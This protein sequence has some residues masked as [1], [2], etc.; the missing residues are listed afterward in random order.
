M[1]NDDEQL[2]I[3]PW[4]TLLRPPWFFANTATA[5]FLPGPSHLLLAVHA[6]G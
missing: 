6:I 2:I 1:A 5:W 4:P 3:K